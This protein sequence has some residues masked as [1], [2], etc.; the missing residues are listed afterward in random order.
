M[1]TAQESTFV[2]YCLEALALKGRSVAFVHDG[3]AITAEECLD[4]VHALAETLERRGVDKGTTVC[5]IAGNLPEAFLLQ[6][7]VLMNGGIYCGLHPMGSLDDHR[8]ILEDTTA[9]VLAYDPRKFTDRARELEASVDLVVSLGPGDVGEDVLAPAVEHLGVRRPCLASPADPSIVYYTGGTTGLPKGVVHTH[10]SN[11]YMAM[12]VQG[13]WEWPRRPSLLLVAPITHAAGQMIAPAL[14]LRGQ[15]VLHDGFDPQAFLDAVENDDVS[16]SFVVPTMLYALLDTPGLEDRDLSGLE[17]LIYGA[18]SIAPERL[19]QAQ[20]VF[21][22][23]LFQGYG[24]TELGIGALQ[25]TKDEHDFDIPGRVGSTGRPPAGTRVA[26]LDDQGREVPDGTT[27]EICFQS[28]SVMAGYLNKPEQTAEALAGGWLHSGDVGFRDAE[29]F[30]S[31]VDRKK[32]MIVTGGF[33]V[34]SKEVED[35][36]C[37]HPDVLLAAV[38]GV[39]DPRWGEA[40]HAMVTV[41][42][43]TAPSPEDLM[44]WVKKRKGSVHAPKTVSFV[45]DLPK[46]MLGKI[47]KKAIR[48]AASPTQSA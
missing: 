16:A 20:A 2:Q 19:R 46:T 6:L 5:V 9:A 44:A 7:A 15:V 42:P 26:I 18:A 47:D 3:R 14:A 11:L 1:S 37:S 48:S 28:G 21:G 40:V 4:L 41:A 45:D 22:D 39:P 10:R 27:G 8:Y 34:Y 13:S 31:I 30:V 35:A 24:Q 36:L 25:L 32:D 43:G 23:A 12:T 29:G 17:T 38:V 33:N